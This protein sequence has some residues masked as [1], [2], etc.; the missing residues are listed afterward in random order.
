MDR[1]WRPMLMLTL[2]LAI[3]IVPF[4]FLHDRFELFMDGLTQEP[5][6]AAVVI[7]IVVGLLSTD[8]FLPIP[9]SVV[10]TLAGSTLSIPIAT[11][12]SWMGMTL[13][14]ML[15]FFVARTFGSVLPTWIAP[16]ADA[17]ELVPV[18]E[19]Y[20][21]F[22]L[23]LT[24]ALPVFAE[25]SVLLVGLHR[26]TWR[27]FLPPIALSNLGICLAYSV[28]GNYASKNAWLPWALGVSI[29]LPLLLSEVARRIL[30]WKSF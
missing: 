7:A 2:V 25:A 16:K 12:A 13:G 15:G 9:S 29:A 24:R 3:P 4:I 27:Q 8:V 23:V 30:R 20:G 11:G 14:A 17:D 21:S 28:L 1:I 5:P 22:V 10:T 18:I 6:S 19:R 26:M